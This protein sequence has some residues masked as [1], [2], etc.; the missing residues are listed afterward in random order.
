MHRVIRAYLTRWVVL[1]I[2]SIYAIQ[3]L[4]RRHSCVRDS[5]ELLEPLTKHL[6]GLEDLEGGDQGV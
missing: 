2:C 3:S 1:F 5:L 6:D 4:I